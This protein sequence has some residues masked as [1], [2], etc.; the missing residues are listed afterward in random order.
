MARI[1]RDNPGEDRERENTSAF[2]RGIPSYLWLCCTDLYMHVR[3]HLGGQ[4]ES[5]E[6]GW[7]NN[8]KSSQSD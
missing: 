3:K 8:S 6:K 7:W 4:K 2:G 5:L 1:C